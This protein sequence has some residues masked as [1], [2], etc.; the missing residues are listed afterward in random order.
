MDRELWEICYRVPE[1]WVGRADSN[2][3][4]RWFSCVKPCDLSKN[5][6]PKLPNAIALIGFASDEGVK[7]N[8]GRPGASEGPSSIREQLANICIQK[9]MPM[10]YDLGD[11]TCRMGDLESAQVGLGQ[12]VAK[13][14]QSN[15]LP[16]VL[17]GGHEVAWGHY[18]GL[19]EHTPSNLGII[20]FDAHFDLRECDKDGRGSSG[21][22]FLQIA[23]A[24]ESAR[25]KF[26]YLCLGIQETANT[27][28]LFKTAEKYSV[29]YAMADMLD[30]HLDEVIAQVDSYLDVHEAIYL[31]VCMD[32]FASSESPGVSA[33]Q[34]MGV[35]PKQILPLLDKI[36]KSGKVAAID[37]AECSPPLDVGA[38]TAKLAAQLIHR[39]VCG[40]VA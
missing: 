23:K 21:T 26:S 17:G 31:S 32:V 3:G 8:F 2:S 5:S 33:P 39:L 11:I 35:T 29:S 40:V 25:E 36:I 6:F 34:V 20:N 14:K 18:Q 7:R 9:K 1:P 16:V 10:I 22:P 30:N 27:K 37:I 13:A 28:S 24:R 4:E 19:A 38:R 12:L 15:M